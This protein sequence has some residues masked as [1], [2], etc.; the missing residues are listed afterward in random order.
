MGGTG[1]K[2]QEAGKR[3]QTLPQGQVIPLLG[4]IVMEMGT[5]QAGGKPAEMLFVVDQAE[6]F[7][8]GGMAK[9][10]PVAEGGGREFLQDL[11]PEIVRGNF[12]GI[13]AAFQTKAKAQRRR[14]FPIRRRISSTRGQTSAKAFSML[15]MTSI[16]SRTNSRALLS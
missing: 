10:V 1:Q 15:R 8:G 16:F 3:N 6:N 4:M 13:L 14:L 11:F 12:A 5:D 2:G 7:L 9:V